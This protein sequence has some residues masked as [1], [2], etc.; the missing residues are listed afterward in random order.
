MLVNATACMGAAARSRF[1]LF[2]MCD[3]VDDLRFGP[4]RLDNG[5]TFFCL[6]G[7]SLCVKIEREYI[8]L[9]WLSLLLCSLYAL[10]GASSVDSRQDPNGY[11]TLGLSNH[12]FHIHAQPR[13]CQMVFG[14]HSPSLWTH[15]ETVCNEK[16]GT[17][18]PHEMASKHRGI[19]S[20]LDSTPQKCS[21]GLG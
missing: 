12:P 19:F 21:G 2:S 15:K 14:K 6:K 10:V 20:T 18:V 5:T 17:H 4:N 13:R 7:K 8:P 3:C 11:A 9:A 1:G 16:Q